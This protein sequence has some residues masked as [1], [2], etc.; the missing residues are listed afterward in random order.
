VEKAH[1]VTEV[2]FEGDRLSLVVDG[3]K[4]V[5]ALAD[6]SRKLL[7][8]TADARRHFVVS[9][10]GYGIH[11]PGLDEDLSVERLIAAPPARSLVRKGKRE[12][13]GV[14]ADSGSR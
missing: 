6:C 5:I 1:E 13:R 4:H 8:A 11:W 9:P 2:R 10:S 14:P 12:K 7:E 3:R